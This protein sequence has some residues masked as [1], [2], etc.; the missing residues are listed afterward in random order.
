MP[1]EYKIKI[2]IKRGK[3]ASLMYSMNKKHANKK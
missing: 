3:K 1:L 2:K